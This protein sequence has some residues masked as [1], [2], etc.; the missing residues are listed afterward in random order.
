ME[1]YS[2]ISNQI[3]SGNIGKVYQIQRKE[4]PFNTLIAKIFEEKG[5]DQYNNEKEILSIL[6]NST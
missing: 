4:P 1:N 6:S 3:G 2:I 5:R